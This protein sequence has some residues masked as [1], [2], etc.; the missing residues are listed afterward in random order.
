MNLL[1]LGENNRVCVCLNTCAHVSMLPLEQ[2]NT[3]DAWGM[4]G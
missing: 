2:L 3:K 1:T 4:I